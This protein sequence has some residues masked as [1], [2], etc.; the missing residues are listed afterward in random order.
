MVASTCNATP[1]VD[2]TAKKEYLVLNAINARRTSTILPPDVS[3]SH[4][5]FPYILKCAKG[6]N[7]YAKIGAE[8]V[9]INVLPVRKLRHES[10]ISLLERLRGMF[11][12]L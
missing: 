11:K 2:V 4:R 10:R 1:T 3:V 12:C 7:L 8:F 5:I 6:P 9:I